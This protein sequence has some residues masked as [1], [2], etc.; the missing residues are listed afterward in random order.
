MK[1]TTGSKIQTDWFLVLDERS[2][3]DGTAVIVN[4]EE[5]DG[6]DEQVREV[7]V[8]WKVSSRYLAAASICHPGID[9]LKEIAEGETDGV[10]RD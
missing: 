2:A 9:E 4:V 8:E 6:G 1:K 5:G 3:E 10:L 7:R